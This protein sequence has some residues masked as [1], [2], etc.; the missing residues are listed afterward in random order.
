MSLFVVRFDKNGGYSITHCHRAPSVQWNHIDGPLLI[1]T[2]GTL[3][4]LS[5]LERFALLLNLTDARRIEDK[6]IAAT[7]NQPCS[8]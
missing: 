1:R 8:L 6:L 7:E 5:W 2:D 3:H 4:W